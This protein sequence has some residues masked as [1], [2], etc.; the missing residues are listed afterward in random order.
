MS[1]LKKFAGNTCA[2]DSFCRMV[3]AVALAATTA[4]PVRAAEYVPNPTIQ[5]VAT[6]I[7]Y[8][9]H[10]RCRL[11]VMWTNDKVSQLPVLVWFHGGGLVNGDKFF[12]LLCHV[13]LPPLG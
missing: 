1:I 9:E 5:N 4:F 2:Q 13:W 3:F 6:N 11:D 8:G 7:V 12:R 10:E